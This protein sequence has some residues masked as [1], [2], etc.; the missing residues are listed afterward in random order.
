MK[1]AES[2]CLVS[3]VSALALAGCATNVVTLPEEDG[4]STPELSFTMTMPDSGREF[5]L[6]NDELNVFRDIDPDQS[7]IVTATA[8]DGARGVR[9]VTATVDLDFECR[10]LPAG[11]TEPEPMRLVREAVNQQEIIEPVEGGGIV[12]EARSTALSFQFSEADKECERSGLERTRGQALGVIRFSATN[13]SD[14]STSHS[15]DVEF[16]LQSH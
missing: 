3:V 9:R 8:E 1:K 2:L 11:Q 6:V 15:H 10:L 13:Y 12:P 5:E 7:V 16:E 14:Q 4:R